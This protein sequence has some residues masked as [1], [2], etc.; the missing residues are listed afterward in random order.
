[1]GGDSSQLAHLEQN[2][3]DAEDLIEERRLKEKNRGAKGDV[4]NAVKDVASNGKK[5]NNKNGKTVDA[6]KDKVKSKADD[7]DMDMDMES[8]KEWMKI[9][10]GADVSKEQVKEKM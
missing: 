3:H 7:M 10:M 6:V 2:S 5:K 4:V 1:M 8:K 9:K